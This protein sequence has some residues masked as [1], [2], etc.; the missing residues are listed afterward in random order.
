M[1]RIQTEPPGATIELST[2]QMCVAP[3]AMEVRRRGELVVTA[4]LEGC[5]LERVPIESRIDRLGGRTLGGYGGVTLGIFAY[6]TGEEVAD[7]IGSAVVGSLVCGTFGADPRNCV[8]RIEDDNDEY[9]ALLPLVPAAVDLGT[10][11]AFVRT[12]NPIRIELTCE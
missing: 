5:G 9:L 12:P 10:G 4:E 11:A 7:A 6:E 8:P 1:L 3:C 2:G